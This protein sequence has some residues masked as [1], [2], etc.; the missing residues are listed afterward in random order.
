MGGLLCY[1]GILR[2]LEGSTCILSTEVDS[3]KI[4]PHYC[5]IQDF[6]E[7]WYQQ[8]H[9]IV[10]GLDSVVARRWINSVLVSL[11]QYTDGELDQS[12]V[13][14][15]IDGGTEGFKGSARVVL[16]GMTAC[17]ECTLDLFPPQITF[18]MCTIAHTPRLP[19]HCI[20][21]VKVLLWPKDNPFGG[22]ECAIDGDDPQHISWIYEQSLKRAAEF[23]ITGVTYRLTQGVIKHIIPAVASTN[24]VIA[25]AC[26]TECLKVATQVAH[27][28]N[29]YCVFNDADGIYTY[30]YE[31]EKKSTCLVCSQVPQELSMAPTDSL[32]NLIDKLKDSPQYQVSV[33][34]Y[35]DNISVKKIELKAKIKKSNLGLS[36]GVQ[37]AV[38]DVT[39]PNSI[40]FNL[41]LSLPMD[42][43]SPLS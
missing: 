2:R 37:L 41:R 39:S 40:I 21:Y 42:V 9:I 13:I 27:H 17:I 5:K 24:A 26:A 36:D 33:T 15:L 31:H 3:C 7:S 12:S 29:N 30:T 8:F 20:E 14:P 25:A 6:D 1:P 4:T 32:Q 23:N 28:M 11:L 34:A 22:D 16:P 35:T 10:C 18:P 38:A 43:S 19:E